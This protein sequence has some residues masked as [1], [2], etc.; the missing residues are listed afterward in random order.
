MCGSVIECLASK[1]KAP[2]SIPSTTRTTLLIYVAD[3]TNKK[4]FS[5]SRISVFIFLP[6]NLNME[7][8][9]A[10][11]STLCCC[12]LGECLMQWHE[13]FGLVAKNK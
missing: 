13:E 10:F 4:G 9:H 7:T 12:I 2:S 11:C 5:N 6:V 1:S 8:Q 3:E